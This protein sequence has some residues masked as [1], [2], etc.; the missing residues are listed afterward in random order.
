MHLT[1][2]ALALA[3][4]LALLTWAAALSSAAEGTTWISLDKQ[5][6]PAAFASGAYGYSPALN[7]DGAKV[8]FESLGRLD[9]ERDANGLSDVYIKDVEEGVLEIVSVA[10]SGEPGN[11]RSYAPTMSA[12]GSVVAFESLA[13]NLVEGDANHASDIYLRDLTDG[14]TVRVSA[15]P[16]GGDSNGPSFRSAISSNGA[17]VVFCSGASNLAADDTNGV[18]DL[19]IWERETVSLSRVEPPGATSTATDGCLRAAVSADASFIA[20]SSVT[21]GVSGVYLYDR[22]A[23]STTAITPAGNGPSGTTGLAISGDGGTVVFDS[24]ADNLIGE[25]TNRSRDVFVYDR[26]S[27]STTRASIRTS[28][29]QLPGESGTS[30]VSV[31]ADGNIIVFSSRPDGVVAGDSNGREDVFLRDIEAG[32]TLIAS[33][34]VFGQSANNSSYSPSTDADGS[35]VA[36]ASLAANLVAGD[37]NRQPDVFI[38]DSDFP[39]TAGSVTGPEETGPPP[40]DELPMAGA[41]DDG[42]TSPL[43]I[44]GGVAAGVLM[45]LLG[46]S[47]LLGRRGR[48]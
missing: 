41:T 7:E 23:G 48:A 2:L 3:A 5:G 8:A 10:S 22:A 1:R 36:F 34:N 11:G 29:S 43:L 39:D 44:Y 45:L 35:V 25:D 32:R 15:P 37:S 21:A 46:V 24:L 12:D 31:S 26:G 28:G 20:F 47:L 6:S 16:G 14:E 17:F 4:A 30:G 19:L 40:E 18:A 13:G 9:I 27:G 33:V 42:G 38:R